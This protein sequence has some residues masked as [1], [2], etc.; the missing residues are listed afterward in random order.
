M[1][2]TM[3]D[4]NGGQ[5]PDHRVRMEGVKV[6]LNWEIGKPIERSITISQPMEDDDEIMARMLQSPAAVA[7][8]KRKIEKA[9]KAF[10]VTIDA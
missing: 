1:T 6:W 4:R 10:P 8:L 9:E 3:Y 2:A 5:V 7:A